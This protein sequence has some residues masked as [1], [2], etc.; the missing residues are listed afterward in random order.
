MCGDARHGGCEHPLGLPP[1]RFAFGCPQRNRK[2][3]HEHPKA[4]RENRHPPP[5]EQNKPHTVPSQASGETPKNKTPNV[6]ERVILHTPRGP[7]TGPGVRSRGRVRAWASRRQGASLSCVVEVEARRRGRGIEGQAS[8]VVIVEARPGAPR[9]ARPRRARR[10]TGPVEIAHQVEGH[11]EG[12]R[13]R[14]AGAGSTRGAE[15]PHCEAA[16]VSPAG[17]GVACFVVS[18]VCRCVS[19]WWVGNGEGPAGLALCLVRGLRWWVG[20]W[21]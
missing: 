14:Q 1:S 2:A 3:L 21:G 12:R 6:R 13:G 8:G 4:P 11:Q 18:R 19:L 10:H 16:Q 15:C 17:G 9:R 7:P 20:W 5:Q